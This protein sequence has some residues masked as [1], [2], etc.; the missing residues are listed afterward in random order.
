MI[1]DHELKQDESGDDIRLLHIS[2]VLLDLD[3]PSGERADA[4]FGIGTA[5]VVISRYGGPFA[6]REAVK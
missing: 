2:L 4:R 5:D 6:T 3:V 1:F